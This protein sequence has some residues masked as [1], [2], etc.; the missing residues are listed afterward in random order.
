VAAKAALVERDPEEEEERKLLNFGH[1]LGHALE[2]AGGYQALRHGEAVAYG[3]LFAIELGEGRGLPAADA[4]RLRALIGRMGL[5][6]LPELP[7]EAVWEALGRDKKAR[8]A[9][10]SWVLPRG[11][12]RAEI[13]RDLPAERVRESLRGFLR[14]RGR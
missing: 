4:G 12:G 9:G 11:I 2:T 8:E 1:T 7:L 14:R 10:L 6:D 3:L 5:P 13:T